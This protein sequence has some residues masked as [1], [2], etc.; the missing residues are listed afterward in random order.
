MKTIAIQGIG[1]CFHDMAAREFFHDEDIQI[2]PCESFHALFD[3]LA[4]DKSRFGIVAIENTIAGSLLEN[5]QLIR[6]SGFTIIGEQKLRIK[7]NLCALRGETLESINEVISHPIALMQCGKYLD[8]HK[9]WKVVEFDDT[10]NAART[11]AKKQMNGVA[12]ICGSLAANLYDLDILAEGIETNKHNFTRFLILA[13]SD[14]KEQTPAVSPDKASLVFAV[15][16]NPGSLS[17]VLAII[18]FYGV[19]LTKIQS[20]PIIGREWEYLFYID[21]SFSDYDRYCKSVEAIKP[22]TRDLKILGEYK[23][24]ELY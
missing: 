11:I 15:E 4:E 22:L 10:A 21:V 16:H 1:G 14:Q 18:S 9:N 5:Y 17:Q 3:S 20:L 24:C 13:H 12:A 2:L 8:G 19:N 7:Q 6:D 23:Q